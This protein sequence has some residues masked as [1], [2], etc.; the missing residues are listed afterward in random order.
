[1]ATVYDG[2]FENIIS[3]SRG[4]CDDTKNGFSARFKKRGGWGGDLF[5]K[6]NYTLLCW[7]SH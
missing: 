6:Y 2:H 5:Q 1:M 3:E 4:G 7:Y